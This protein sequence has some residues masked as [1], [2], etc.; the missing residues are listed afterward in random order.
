MTLKELT[1][2]S[3]FTAVLIICGN[4]AI[5]TPIVPFTLQVFA[6]SLIAFTL[7]KKEAFFSVLLYV[8]MGL[9]GL[10]VFSGWTGGLVATIT[11][12]TFGFI[13]GFLPMVFLMSLILEK[14]K[15]KKV[16][17]AVIA[18]AS[19]IVVLYICGLFVVYINLKYY[20]GTPLP[21]GK[22]FMGYCIPFLPIDC[23]K[24]IL[25]YIVA[26][27]LKKI[28]FLEAKKASV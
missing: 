10:P 13:I 25:S 23:L 1:R 26:T 15:S 18:S 27:R 8:I 22:M 4:I 3:V 2:I 21:F 16:L 19:G 11:K 5:P 24:F 7:S 28:V 6:V 14:M 12:P 20:A 17:S 9:I